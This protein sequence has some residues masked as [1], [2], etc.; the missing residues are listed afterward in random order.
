MFHSAII[1]RHFAFR[2]IHEKY[3]S[4][5]MTHEKVLAYGDVA[6]DKHCNDFIDHWCLS[7]YRWSVEVLWTCG[8]G[9]FSRIQ[10]LVLESPRLLTKISADIS[11]IEDLI[12][13]SRTNN[14]Y[15]F[16]CFSPL[17]Y[18]YTKLSN[19][20]MIKE[21]LCRISLKQHQTFVVI[22]SST[23]LKWSLRNS[24]KRVTQ[25]AMQHSSGQRITFM[26]DQQSNVSLIKC[27]KFTRISPSIWSLLTK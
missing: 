21:K 11:D 20:S 23:D 24:S 9:E 5:R 14:I 15:T 12:Y 2:L 16:N 22:S 13:F 27:T 7:L 1:F 25:N 10:K 19:A 8:D 26:N 3:F 6:K 17:K 18:C 4:P